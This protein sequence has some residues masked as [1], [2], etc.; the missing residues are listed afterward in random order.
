VKFEIPQ[1]AGIELEKLEFKRSEDEAEK[2]LR[3]HKEKLTFY[4]RVLLAY[5]FGFVFL[6]V[7]SFYCYWVLFTPSTTPEERRYAWSVLSAVMGAIVGI[8]YGRSTK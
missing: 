3:L 4:F 8:V 1:P 5:V 7:V 2:V 6:A